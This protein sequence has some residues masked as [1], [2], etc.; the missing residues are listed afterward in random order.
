MWADRTTLFAVRNS[1]SLLVLLAAT[2]CASAPPPHAEE[3][4]VRVRDTTVQ[5][6]SAKKS[7][8]A[9]EDPT[10]PTNWAK[11]RQV[12]GLP[13]LH[14]VSDKLWRGGQPSSEGM[15]QLEAFGVRT[16][17]NLRSLHSDRDEIGSASLGY[18]H[19]SMTVFAP[20]YDSVVR[21]LRVMNDPSRQPVFVHCQHGSDRTGVVLAAYR[22][23]VEGWSKDEAVR[24]MV[25][26]GYGFH[27]VWG[28]LIRFVRDLDVEQLRRDV[29]VQ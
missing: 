29:G 25:D 6:P 12:I 16:V 5:V 4:P 1:T 11:P 28:N 27:H 13:N 14:Q 18:E 10:R 23:A 8:G 2:A 19:I 7:T 24:E 3:P 26:G 17:I 15:Q 21:A 22:M 9:A 20:S